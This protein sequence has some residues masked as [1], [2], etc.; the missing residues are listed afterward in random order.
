LEKNCVKKFAS[1]NKKT[2]NITAPG[3]EL[4]VALSSPRLSARGS[5]EG[6][7]LPPC[8]AQAWSCLPTTGL[9][10]RSPWGLGWRFRL[11]KKEREE[12]GEEN[13]ERERR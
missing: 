13:G 8:R 5:P 3:A 1:K 4:T 7:S 12:I 2:K 11:L 9:S 6:Q 10:C